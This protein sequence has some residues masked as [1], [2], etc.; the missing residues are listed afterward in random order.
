MKVRVMHEAGEELSLM[1]MAYSYKDR[2][3][4]PAAWWPE[5]KAKAYRRAAVLA[6]RD[7][8]HNKFL[9]SVM[10]WIDIEASRD[11]WSEF[12][13]YRVGTT[14]QSE[15]TMHTLA[16][17]PP[18]MDD[19]ED[20]TDP[21]LVSVFLRVWEDAKGDVTTLKKNLPEGFL[22]RRMVCTSYK[23]LRAVL[24]QRDGHRL[25][26]WAQ[27]R[28]DLLAQIARPEWLVEQPN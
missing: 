28:A 25:K 21:E 24:H 9:E 7:G 15:S 5:Q 23:T 3:M 14:K 10:V 12:D 8:G 11:W 18:R 27:F 13:T 20:G 22:Q 6:H 1:G 17:R 19:F 26:Q 16:K 4:D 2:A